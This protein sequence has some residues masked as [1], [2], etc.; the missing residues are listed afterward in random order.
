MVLNVMEASS[1][2]MVLRNGPLKWSYETFEVNPRNGNESLVGRTQ[3]AIKNISC[4]TIRQIAWSV[5]MDIAVHQ[6]Q[7]FTL[8]SLS[9]VASAIPRLRWSHEANVG[10]HTQPIA[11]PIV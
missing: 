5:S 11:G 6:S 7:Q 3:T 4:Y 9:Q 10:H 8:D 2:V 1:K